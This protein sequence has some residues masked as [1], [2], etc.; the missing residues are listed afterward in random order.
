M[1]A[2]VGFVTSYTYQSYVSQVFVETSYIFSQDEI[3]TK[4][5]KDRRTN[6]RDVALAANVSVA[7]VS[8]VL[9]TPEKVS[10]D[11]RARVEK[12]IEKLDFVPSPAAIAINSGRSKILGALIPTLESDIF[13]RTINAIENTLADLGYSLVVATTNDDPKIEAGKAKELLKIGVEGLFLTGVNH[14]CELLSMIERRSIPSVVL[15]FYD[16]SYQLPTISYDNFD[17]GQKSANYLTELGCETIAFISGPTLNNDRARARLLGV[18]SV[19]SI[20]TTNHIETAL[21]IEG[22]SEACLDLIRLGKLPDAILCATDFL[23][24]GVM[25]ELQR[26]GINVPKDI[27][28]MGLHNLPGSDVIVPRLTTV[29][30]PEKVM[31]NLSANALVEWLDNG[32]PPNHILLDTEIVERDSSRR[33]GS[34]D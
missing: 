14:D 2:P 12:I 21:S 6:L 29:N 16:P 9:N 18:Q 15:S 27:L 20:N 24:Y 13:A 19:S 3:M 4:F 7:T 5:N 32:G 1:V 10:P 30:L 33:D 8:R 23:A 11:T 26:N 34:S 17:V 22:G 31:G 28:V 25:H